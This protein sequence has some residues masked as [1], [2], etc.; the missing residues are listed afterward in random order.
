MNIY[1]IIITNLV[2]NSVIHEEILLTKGKI[3]NHDMF[4]VWDFVCGYEHLSEYFMRNF[5]D[6]LHWDYIT[7]DQIL[8]KDFVKDM[9]QE[10]NELYVYSNRIKYKSGINVYNLIGEK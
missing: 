8:S 5:K 1:E 6:Y 9:I 4:Y 3:D 2:N 10:I 7:T